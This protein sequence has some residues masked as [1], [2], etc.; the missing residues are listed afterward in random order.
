MY[1]PVSTYRLQFNKDFP[2]KKLKVHLEYLHKL[3][4]KSIYASPLFKAT[5][6]SNHGYDVTDPLQINP[7]TGNRDE[8]I[9]IIG[10]LHD[11]EMG[12]LQDIVPNH[13]AFNSHNPYIMD[14]L[15]KGPKSKYADFFDIDWNHAVFNGKLLT[16]FLGSSLQE[17]VE[18]DGIKLI[19]RDRNFLF[20]YYGNHYPLNF[21]STR[22]VFSEIEETKLPEQVI[23]M[24]REIS[25][26]D[27][28]GPEYL[29]GA[30]KELKTKLFNLYDA[31]KQTNQ[32]LQQR[33]RGI[34]ENRTGIRE[35]LNMQH[36][37][38]AYWQETEKHINY[39]RFFT[40]NDLICVK[41][42]EKETFEATHELIL[43]MTANKYFNGLRID[44]LDGLYDPVRYLRELRGHVGEE[45]YIAAEKILES[46]ETL[47]AEWPMQGTSGYDFLARVNNLFTLNKNYPKL[48][49]FYHHITG[50]KE[51]ASDIIYKRK[52][53]ILK[54]RMLGELNNLYRMFEALG[55][56]DEIRADLRGDELK[57]AIEEFLLNCPVYKLYSNDLPLRDQDHQMVQRIIKIASERKPQ[58]S[59]ALHVLGEIF[60]RTEF[61]NLQQKNKTLLLFQRCMQF[62]GPLTAKGVEDTTMY[63]YNCFAAHNEVGDAPDASGISIQEFHNAMMQRQN[64]WPLSMN[65][66]AT[67]DTKRGEDV[68]ARLNVISELPDEWME[69][70]RKWININ[71]AHKKEIDG[72]AAPTVNEE[73]LVYQTLLGIWPFDGKIDE[74]FRKRLKEYMVKAMRESKRHTNWKQPNEEY[75][76][77]VNGFCMKIIRNDSEFRKSFED[78]VRK[79]SQYGIYN[80]FAQLILKCTCPGVPDFYRGTERWDLSLVDPDNRRP[81]DFE[82]RKRLLD[83]IIQEFDRNA[84][85]LVSKLWEQRE[86]GRFKLFLSW[87]LLKERKENPELFLKGKYIP[88]EVTGSYREH[89][90]A[91]MRRHE[92]KSLLIILPI[93]LADLKENSDFKGDWKDTIVTTPGNKHH[94]WINLLNRQEIDAVDHIEMQGEMPLILKAIE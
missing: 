81:V 62:T 11:K 15:E 77:T 34:N 30:W 38:L 84:G 54:K 42:E 29:Y 53:F 50:I 52:V 69:H 13:M 85:E 63:Y 70:V 78:L 48:R 35:L 59:Y 76:D 26:I 68:R 46:K 2:L 9:S 66:T 40:I 45:T 61:D 32:L 58:L 92:D 80:S 23:P 86:D 44:H 93:Y 82:L 73:Y 21:E 71:S 37:L 75:E 19:I 65:A 24:I 14:V 83:G 55:F 47:P 22:K 43:S 57:A 31:D 6:G 3:N 64:E 17:V 67:H 94:K 8:L 18:N 89:I 60:T 20:D 91:F 88:L 33:I 51:N 39:R 16:P 27:N 87:L 28:P 74:S 10:E 72:Q 5:P 49:Q 41:A 25:A 12:W 7:E 90:L 4:I 56:V 36:Y 1:N 79:I